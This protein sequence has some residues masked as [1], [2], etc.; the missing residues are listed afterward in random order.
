MRGAQA[1]VPEAPLGLHGQGDRSGLRAV[2]LG[3]FELMIDTKNHIVA[4]QGRKAKS[5]FAFTVFAFVCYT[6]R[7]RVQLLHCLHY[8]CM[9]VST[10]ETAALTG[11]NFCRND[12]LKFHCDNEE[13]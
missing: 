4:N 3:Q 5:C 11:P 1:S 2:Q 9:P 10:A 12:A 13:R 7:V 6:T 8:A